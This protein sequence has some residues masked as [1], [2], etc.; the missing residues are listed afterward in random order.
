MQRATLGI[1]RANTPILAELR[2]VKTRRLVSEGGHGHAA[3]RLGHLSPRGYDA[4]LRGAKTQSNLYMQDPHT[5]GAP[6]LSL[7]INGWQLQNVPLVV[8]SVERFVP[9]TATIQ[10]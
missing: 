10:L 6:G 2:G 5:S 1:P 3:G 4:E 9:L 7:E 8:A